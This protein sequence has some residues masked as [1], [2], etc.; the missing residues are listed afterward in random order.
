MIEAGVVINTHGEPIHWH[1][2]RH[3]SGAIPDSRQLWDVLWKAHADGWLDGVAHSHP[4]SGIPGPSQ[5]DLSTFVAI[6][7]ALGRS[8]S[9]W[10][11]S[12]DKTVVCNRSTMDSVPGRVIYAIRT[13]TDEPTWILELRRRSEIY[14]PYR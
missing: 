4:G 2:P 14:S 5:E 12:V 13:I 10:I 1:E 8:L 7:A 11:T 9:W 6:E 3:S